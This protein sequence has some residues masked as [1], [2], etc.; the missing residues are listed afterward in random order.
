MQLLYTNHILKLLIYSI[1]PIIKFKFFQ[2]YLLLKQQGS[3]LSTILLINTVRVLCIL[4]TYHHYF[5]LFENEQAFTTEIFNTSISIHKHMT[6][7]TLRWTE[8]IISG[9]S[10]GSL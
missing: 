4:Y 6:V 1:N 10:T 3:L 2:S 7:L 9:M 8:C 5:Q